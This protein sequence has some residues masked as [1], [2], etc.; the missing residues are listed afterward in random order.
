MLDKTGSPI[1]LCTYTK[2]ESPPNSLDA[3]K[4]INC[5]WEGYTSDALP[6]S[7]DIILS[8]EDNEGNGYINGSNEPFRVYD[9]R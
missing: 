3:E 7:F 8:W 6:Y 4:G 5:F 2:I 9:Y 1:T